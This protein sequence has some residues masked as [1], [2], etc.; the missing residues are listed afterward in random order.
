L[1]HTRRDLHRED[2]SRRAILGC[3]CG[4]VGASA[5]PAHGEADVR[6]GLTPV[7]RDNDMILLSL[8]QKYLAR[9]LERPVTLVRRRTHREISSMLLSGEIDAAWVSDF[10]YVQDQDRLALLAVPVYSHQ[11]LREA[12]V[13]VNK[14]SAAMTFDDIRGTAHAFSDPDSTSGYLITRWLLAL[15]GET[16]A[17]F[18]RNSFFTYSPRNII[19]AVGAGLGQSGSVEGYVWDVMKE[20]EPALA[21]ETRVVFRSEPLGFPPIVALKKSRDVAATQALATA[22]L[23]MTL[24][25]L[26]REIL[27]ILVL[28]GFTTASPALYASVA[29]K[30]QVVRGQ[31]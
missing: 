21:D 14:A 22:L 1:R 20:R 7:F 10:S 2:I 16:P 3:F 18:F 13:I 6:F 26:G 4:L 17:G 24:N 15:R 23:G 19:R 30:W 28:D 8:L 31:E 29:E 5:I 27:T 12:Y 9:S 11:P 25:D